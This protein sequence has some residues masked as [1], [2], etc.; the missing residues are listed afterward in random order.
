MNTISN[1]YNHF[2]VLLLEPQ[3]SPHSTQ[4]FLRREPFTPA[5]LKTMERTRLWIDER[6]EMNS[7]ED[8]DTDEVKLKRR[9]SCDDTSSFPGSHNSDGETRCTT[10]EETASSLWKCSQ[11]QQSFN[12]RS[13]LRIHMCPTQANKPFDCGHCSRSFADANDLRN[14]VGTHTNDRLFK[15]GYCGRR[16]AG[17]TTLTNHIRTHTGEKPFSCEKCGKN[18]SQAS[19]LNRHQRM[20]ADCV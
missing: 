6:L 15:C 18:F 17:A 1:K 9:D 14:H 12:Q 2:N 7:G 16:F 8:E 13:A 4:Q 11:C 3:S 5:M 19:Q 20:G 10:P